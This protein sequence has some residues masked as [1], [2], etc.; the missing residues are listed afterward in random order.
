MV[1]G[2]KLAD[3]WQR[4][5]YRVVVACMGSETK[6]E[7]IG[8]TLVVHSRKDVFLKDPWNY[9]IALGFGGFVAKLA[10]VVASSGDRRFVRYA[11]RLSARLA[12]P[13]RACLAT[14]IGRGGFFLATSEPIDERTE[15]RCEISLPELRRSL[16]FVGEVLYRTELQGVERQGIGVRIREISPEDEAALIEYVALRARAS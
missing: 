12:D 1:S 11:G 14:E 15:M 7:K 4:L 16:D 13:N 9:G 6:T 3:L 5:G 10:K 2:Y 8:E